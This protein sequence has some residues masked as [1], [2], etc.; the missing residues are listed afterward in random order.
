MNIAFL[1]LDDPATQT[2]MQSVVL[3][4]I[5]ALGAVLTATITLASK[6]ALQWLDGKAHAA[7]FQCAMSKIE[8]VTRSA[9]DE[10]EQTLVRQ[11]KED[12]R[13]DVETARGA[14]DTA[15]EIAK[16]HLGIRGMKELEGCLGHAQDS[17]EGILRTHV[18]MYVK[19]ENV[20]RST[21]SATDGKKRPIVRMGK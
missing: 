16:R 14:R 20:E 18:E 7:T 15:V 11:L 17:I 12:D 19:R 10:V 1:S 3:A 13:W 4:V 2:L 6:K 21:G 5:S 9:V 8:S